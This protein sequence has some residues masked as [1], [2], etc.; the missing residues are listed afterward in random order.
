MLFAFDA[1]RV[2]EPQIT[3][4]RDIASLLKNV[5]EASNRNEALHLLR[6]LVA[7]LCNLS[8]KTFLG[9]KNLQ[10]EVKNLHAELLRYINGWLS[11]S[12][13][14]LTRTVVRN[15]SSVIGKPNLIDQLWNDTI[16]LAEVEVRGSAIVNELRRSSH[17]ALG[18]RT[19]HLAESYLDFLDRGETRELERL[20]F[21]YPRQPISR[22]ASGRNREESWPESWRTSAG[23]WE[24]P[25]RLRGSRNGRSPMPRTCCNVSSGHRSRS[26]WKMSSQRAS[27]P[28]SVGL[29]PPPPHLLH[30]AEDFSRPED[31]VDTL[32]QSRGAEGASSRRPILRRRSRGNGTGGRGRLCPGIRAFYQDGLFEMLRP[33]S[34][35][36]KMVPRSRPS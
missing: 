23:C 7:R 24:P 21:A 9:A 27:R 2:S 22:R 4:I 31:V 16:R 36:T 19:L 17:H 12:V 25:K 35:P 6:H 15:L 5:N 10:P 32:K 20:G 1:D 14:G 33:C 13:P 8:V 3:R 34:T 18:Q 11:P 28:Q 30:K 26:S 29:L